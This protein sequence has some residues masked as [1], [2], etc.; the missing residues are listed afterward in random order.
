[1]SIKSIKYCYSI[2]TDISSTMEFYRDVLGLPVKFADPG[3]W[4]QFDLPDGSGFALSSPDEA[5]VQASGSVV[6]F[7]VDDIED[8]RRTMESHGSYV[9]RRDMGSHGQVVTARDP[10]GNIIQFFQK[11]KDEAGKK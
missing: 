10:S 3:K 8:V 11:N 2:S 1:M 6:V 7:D 4:V 9:G 5:A